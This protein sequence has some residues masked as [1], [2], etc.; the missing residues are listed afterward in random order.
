[1]RVRLG[2]PTDDLAI[3]L[4]LVHAKPDSWVNLDLTGGAATK[5][6]ADQVVEAPPELYNLFD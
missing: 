5:P 6:T 1:M 3:S 2:E 4:D